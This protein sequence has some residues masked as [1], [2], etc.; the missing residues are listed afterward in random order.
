MSILQGNIAI[1]TV[2]YA[3]RRKTPTIVFHSLDSCLGL[4]REGH[5]HK[6]TATTECAVLD[7]RKTT[8]KCHARKTAAPVEHLITDA[9]HAIRYRHA[10][11]TAATLKRL[12]PD[13]R[14]AVWYRHA[15]KTTTVDKR[16]SPDARYMASNPY[17]C[18]VFLV[19]N[20]T[21]CQLANN[22]TLP[23]RKSAF[24]SVLYSRFFSTNYNV[25]ICA[26]DDASG[27]KLPWI[28]VHSFYGLSILATES[29]IV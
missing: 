28:F 5:I 21:A 20:R 12:I 3:A 6:T 9:R 18:Y 17:F 22:V 19:W 1:R 25:P 27:M 13:A 15:R 4:A 14:H 7:S 11:N 29:D 23:I 24:C 8:S 16:I 2:D 10:H 26:M